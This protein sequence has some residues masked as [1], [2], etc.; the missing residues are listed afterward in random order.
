MTSLLFFKISFFLFSVFVKLNSSFTFL[1][2]F[3]TITMSSISLN[4]GAAVEKDGASVGGSA[5]IEVV[6]CNENTYTSVGLSTPG[7]PYISNG[8]SADV[9]IAGGDG[10]GYVTTSTYVGSDGSAGVS[11]DMGVQLDHKDTVEFVGR[12]GPEDVNEIL[13]MAETIEASKLK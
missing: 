3:A 4:L 8:I 2:K 6:Y 7:L 1:V 11:V 5:Y 13:T 12:Y 10:P 9:Q